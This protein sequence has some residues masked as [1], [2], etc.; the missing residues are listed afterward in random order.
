M[1]V[2]PLRIG[3]V[4]M[5]RTRHPRRTLGSRSCAS[6]RHRTMVPGGGPAP[7]G[8]PSLAQAPVARCTSIA[9][10]PAPFLVEMRGRPFAQWSSSRD[11]ER[12]IVNNRYRSVRTLA[13]LLPHI[14]R[15][16]AWTGS[17]TSRTLPGLRDLGGASCSDRPAVGDR[18]GDG[19]ITAMSTERHYE[20]YPDRS[21]R[22]SPT[23]SIGNQSTLADSGFRSISVVP[24]IEGDSHGQADRCSTMDERTP[25]VEP[26]DVAELSLLY[27]LP[28][29][30][31]L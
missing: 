29:D 20:F 21:N 15:Y 11:Q 7:V 17:P 16:R 31:G 10:A 23:V 1:S 14:V 9:P 2:D 8:P 28:V 19:A 22:S 12:G 5:R 3:G 25:P 6:A 4:G 13:G 30:V 26:T 18:P 24:R 27:P